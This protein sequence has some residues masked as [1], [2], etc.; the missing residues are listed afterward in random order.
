MYPYT[1]GE[2]GLDAAMPTWV[3][4]G[5]FDAWPA[6]LGDPVIRAR[7]V[8][9][10]RAP[11]AGWE[12]MLLAA[13]SADNVLLVGF[14]NPKLKPLTGQTLGAIARSRGRSPEDTAIDLVIEDQ[15]RVSTVYFVMSEDNVKLGLSQPWVSLDSDE[16]AVAPDG[17]FLLSSSHPR[18]YGAFARFLGKY[19]REDK[20]TSLPD[21]IRRLT[22]LPAQNF[23]LRERGCIDPGCH[24]D[25]VVFDPATVIDHATYEK[26]RQFATGVSDVVVNG[27]EVFKDG[28]ST[29]AKPGQVVRGAGWTGWQSTDAG[30]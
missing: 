10:M 30:R 26:P 2:T 22:R 11:G 23:R 27:I 28:K 29:G 21:A 24:A 6:R 25:L 18:A 1:A 3:Q 9:E 7:V 8:K 12:N 16:S 5:G 17:I 15:S 4:E 14:R 20:V 19:V 13:G